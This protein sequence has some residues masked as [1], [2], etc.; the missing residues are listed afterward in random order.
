MKKPLLPIEA[1]NLLYEEIMPGFPKEELEK[2]KGEDFH[3]MYLI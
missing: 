1:K 2:I 3:F